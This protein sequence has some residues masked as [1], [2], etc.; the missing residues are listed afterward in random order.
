MLKKLA[1]ALAAVVAIAVVPAQ[2]A[3]LPSY[4]PSYSDAGVAEW[5]IGRRLL[6]FS[7]R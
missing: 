7:P 3:D 6:Q 2:A 5:F 1:V 4:A